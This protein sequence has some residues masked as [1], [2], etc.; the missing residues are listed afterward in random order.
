MFAKTTLLFLASA[1]LLVSATP[2]PDNNNSCNTDSMYCC[3]QVHKSESAEY[4]DLV[5][6]Y[7]LNVKAI[8]GNIGV[9]CSPITGL[10]VGGGP[11]CNQ[12]PVCCSGNN[13]NG[14]VVVGCSPIII[15][16]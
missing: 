9:N 13:F 4:T 7:G 2:V 16:L 10:G 3:N 8:T 5:T 12:Q 11:S 15:N 6:E 1:A 14:L